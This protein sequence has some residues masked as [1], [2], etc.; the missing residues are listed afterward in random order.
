MPARTGACDVPFTRLSRP[1]R[2]AGWSVSRKLSTG[3]PS[4]RST[5]R[6]RY[7]Q[8]RMTYQRS[9]SGP[10][11]RTRRWKNK[12]RSVRSS[13]HLYAQ[14]SRSTRPST[15]SRRFDIASPS[16]FQV[17]RVERSRCR[18]PLMRRRRHAVAYPPHTVCLGAHARR[19][20]VQA[21]LAH[22]RD[23]SVR[24]RYQSPGGAVSGRDGAA[25]RSWVLGEDGLGVLL[26]IS[27]TYRAWH[28]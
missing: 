18:S 4:A 9:L 12:E 6:P 14:R 1:W 22:K 15:G 27:E 26:L 25:G 8:R 11:A 10:G 21:A 17:R 3:V 28:G 5:K 7:K 13:R 2:W 20:P 23:D 19:I 24:H 16:T